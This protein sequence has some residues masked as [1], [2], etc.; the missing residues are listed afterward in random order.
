MLVEG[1]VLK[2]YRL[3]YWGQ[4]LGSYDTAA[5]ILAERK[6]HNELIRPLIDR[7]NKGRYQ[8]REAV[9]EGRDREISLVEL[10]RR[11]AAEEKAAV[12]AEGRRGL[13]EL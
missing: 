13:K 5:E 3:S 8:F 10:R 7:E 12:P 4:F 9:K 6:K 1:A 11:A 2:R